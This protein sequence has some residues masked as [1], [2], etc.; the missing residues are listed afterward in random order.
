MI[1]IKFERGQ[2]SQDVLIVDSPY[3]LVGHFLTLE[4]SRLDSWPLT[5]LLPAVESIRQHE[6][7]T[8][9]Y[10]GDA[11]SID[12][13]LKGV[14][15]QLVVMDP[16]DQCEVPLEDFYSILVR[17]RGHLKG[18]GDSA[19]EGDFLGASPNSALHRSTAGTFH[20][21]GDE[22]LTWAGECP[23]TRGF[24]FGTQSGK[25]LV[26]PATSLDFGA[27]GVSS[28]I[29]GVAFGREFIAIST[30]SEV[31]VARASQYERQFA[32][33]GAFDG[34]ANGIL[35]TP[36]G[37][38]VASRGLHGILL[39][40]RD[41]RA[42]TLREIGLTD[43]AAVNYSR[44]IFAGKR[45]AD[46]FTCAGRGGGLFA[47]TCDWERTHSTIIAHPF[48]GQ[49][50]LDVC[51]IRS[52]EWP[53]AVAAISSDKT[54]MLTSD[55]I[56]ERPIGITIPISGTSVRSI[57]SAE[58]HLFLLTDHS[59]HLFPHLAARFLRGER[60]DQLTHHV[61]MPSPDTRATIAYD[62]YLLLGSGEKVFSVDI[63][64]L[65]PEHFA[66][67]GDLESV[68]EEP[69]ETLFY[70]SDIIPRLYDIPVE[71]A[72]QMDFAFA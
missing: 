9:S 15:L 27:L 8:F 33:V 58:G 48:S 65:I 46:I 51:S 20:R 14:N 60:L 30:P 62:R 47:V 1:R 19:R 66:G 54:I 50:I 41:N 71:R 11:F 63:T 31:I 2:R 45:G 4:S 43:D 40:R 10:G 28:E 64:K 59:L 67:V 44:L 38:F 68:A 18:G 52:R 32:R 13:S 5:K 12:A 36:S 39:I 57:L 25:V 69:V 21:F 3:E 6:L 17:W 49:D 55:V 34:G 37:N 29:N 42:F 35:A 24:C 7:E 22:K 26:P 61:E 23:W 70:T 53:L 72:S 16:P 56:R